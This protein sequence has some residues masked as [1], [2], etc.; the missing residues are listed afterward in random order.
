M[1]MTP[2]EPSIEPASTSD[3]IV[4]RCVKLIRRQQLHGE[5]AGHDRLDRHVVV[6]RSAAPG[7]DQLTQR[8][9]VGQFVQPRTFDIAAQAED[10]H[11]WTLLG[12]E[13]AIPVD[14]V[15]HDVGHVADGLDIVDDGRFGVETLD[16]RK[17]RLHARMTAIAFQ[18][19]EQR[20]LFATLVGTSAAMYHNLQ[21]LAAA[22]DVLPRIALGFGLFN[23]LNQTCIG[24]IVLAADVDEGRFGLNGMGT[25]DD[26]FDQL[27][28]VVLHDDAVFEGAGLRLVRVDHQIAR[29]RIGRQETPFDAGWKAGAAH[30]HGC[31]WP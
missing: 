26:A 14:A 20:R 24:K 21:L 9:G 5:A 4:Q 23:G 16:R 8:R 28:G 1:T 12:A 17:G 18:A 30:V 3:S 13:L 29:K 31:H 2:A 25:E 22:K 6:L 7:V 11:A 15:A 10:A 19:G 27:M